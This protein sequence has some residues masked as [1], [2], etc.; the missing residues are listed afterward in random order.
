MK[1]NHLATIYSTI[2]LCSLSTS[3]F[4]TSHTHDLQRLATINTQLVQLKS[5]LAIDKVQ[6]HTL[7]DNLKQNEIDM[8]M[9]LNQSRLSA[10]RVKQEQQQLLVL[11]NKQAHYQDQ[12]HHQQQALSVQ[13]QATY[14]M[15]K[16]ANLKLLLNQQNAATLSRSFTYLTYIDQQRLQEIEALENTLDMLH[17]NQQIINQHTAKLIKLNQSQKKQLR[18]LHQVQDKRQ[19]LLK[20]INRHIDTQT[21]KFNNLI[22]DK[23]SLQQLLQGLQR[24]AAEADGDFL[25]LPFDKLK[26]KFKWPIIGK[27]INQFGSRIKGSELHW[28]GVLMKAAE[29][30]NIHAIYPGKVIFADW[31]RGYGLVVILDHGS[32]FMT[33]YARNET[34]GVKQGENIQS[35]TIIAQVG[36]SGGFRQSSLYFEIRHNGEPVNPEIWCS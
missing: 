28:S 24:Q 15:G 27:I 33:I 25:P 13:L 21:E 36:K 12:L 20:Q 11:E 19:L 22:S 5:N 35:G 17:Q 31:L 6:Q 1:N 29:G 16:Q 3:V 32:G 34:I 30:V 18:L 2:V 4:A 8:G 9:L 7:T 14:Q 10:K 26:G 23:R